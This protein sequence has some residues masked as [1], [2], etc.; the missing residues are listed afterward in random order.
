L[1][2]TTEIHMNWATFMLLSSPTFIPPDL[3]Y[4]ISHTL[5]GRGPSLRSGPVPLYATASALWS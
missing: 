4:D 1:Q 3:R 5:Y 2:E